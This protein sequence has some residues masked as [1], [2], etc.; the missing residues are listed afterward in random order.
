MPF[1]DIRKKDP[2]KVVQLNTYLQ[3]RFLCTSDA[4]SD[5]FSIKNFIANPMRLTNFYACF[6]DSS[7]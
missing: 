2:H 5:K 3:H 1:F 4:P 7:P 6:I